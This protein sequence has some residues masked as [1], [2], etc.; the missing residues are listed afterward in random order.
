MNARVLGLALLG[1]VAATGLL[2]WGTSIPLGVPGEWTWPRLPMTAETV[3]GACGALIAGFLYVGFVLWGRRG[4]DGRGRV[5]VAGQLLMLVAAAFAWLWTVQQCVPPPADLGKVPYV[6]FYPRSS[7]YFWQARHEVTDTAHFLAH[8][9]DLLAEEDFLHIGT[10]PPGLTLGYR[11]LLVMCESSPGLC[12]VV[13][14]TCPHSVSESLQTITIL[15]AQSGQTV[16]TAD[17]AV[18]WLAAL[19][20][21]LAAAATTAGIYVLVRR[22][23]DRTAAWTAAGLWR[24]ASHC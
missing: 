6:L 5:A 22:H 1:M 18:L 14:A 12:E 13:L 2:L 15:S 3:V 20:T 9:E 19:I 23:F 11:G 16:T 8:Y 24:S 21:L 10:H 4:I 17:Q 7:G